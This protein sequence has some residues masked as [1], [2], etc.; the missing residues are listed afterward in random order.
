M[1]KIDNIEIQPKGEKNLLELIRAAGINLPTFCYSPELSVFGSCRMCIVEI[2]GRGVVPACSTAVVDGMIVRTNTKQL[3]DARKVIL[4]LMLAS[5]DQSCTTCPKSTYCK[6]QEFAKDLG[7][8]KVRFHQNERVG[9]IDDS[10]DAIV[11]DPGK[12]ILCGRC[13]RV[14]SEHQAV[15]A[16]DFAYRGSDSK[17]LTEFNRDMWSTK[18]VSCG[19]CVKQCPVGALTVKTQIDDVWKAISDKTKTVVVQIAPAVRVAVGEY[20]GGKPG[21]FTL[22]K[23]I[24]ALRRIGFDKVY[25]TSFGADLTTV[26]EGREFIKRYKTGGKFPMFTSCCPAWVKYAEHNYPELLPNLS[27]CRS[28][29][30]M[31]GAVAKDKLTK[32][33]GITRKDL[34]VVSVMPC[35]AKKFEARRPELATNKNPDVDFVITTGELAQMIKQAGMD[36]WKLPDGEFDPHL[37]QATGAGVIFGATGGVLEA[38]KRFVTKEIGAETV[39]EVK[40]CV[41]SGLVN[42]KKLLEDIKTG[43]VHYDIIEVM[44]CKGGC[45]NGGGQ[46]DGDWDAVDARRKGLRAND[47][48]KPL[49]TSGENPEIQALYKNDLIDEEKTHHML[50]TKFINRKNKRK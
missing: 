44:A 40:T 20:F 26:E 27:T 2:E 29:H 35:T 49:K 22:G 28:P 48:Q 38:V 32:E 21:E 25:D 5:H 19:Q 24:T 43:K 13:V 15:G 36:F 18:C 47:E 50:H 46:P 37:G 45:V 17:V 11:R 4:E 6:L 10:S 31:F 3:R 39:G 16:L 14:C 9:T 1:V 34:I 41:V 23:I 30:Q 12:C 42:A 8:T 7:V 33:M